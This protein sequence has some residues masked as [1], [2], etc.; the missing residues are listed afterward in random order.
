MTSNKAFA[1]EREKPR[2]LKSDDGIKGINDEL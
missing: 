1:A 2:P